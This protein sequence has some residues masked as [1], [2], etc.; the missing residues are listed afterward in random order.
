M[1]E[2]AMESRRYTIYITRGNRI[3]ECKQSLRSAKMPIYARCRV[4]RHAEIVN[5]V[6]F[7]S[8][9]VHPSA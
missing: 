2:F 3:R 6:G 8:F 4:A 1:V 7:E 5:Q 9:R